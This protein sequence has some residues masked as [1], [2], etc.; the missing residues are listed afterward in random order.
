MKQNHK[1]NPLSENKYMGQN[2]KLNPLDYKKT[3]GTET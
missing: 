3:V 2:H 1:L